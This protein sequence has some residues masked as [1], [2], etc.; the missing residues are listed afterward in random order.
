[1]KSLKDVDPTIYAKA[2]AVLAR[3]P[4]IIVFPLLAA[5]I[6]VGLAFLRGP[7]FDPLGGNDF[8]IFSLIGSLVEGFAFG[9]AL[10]AAES[11]WRGNAVRFNDVWEEGKRKAGAILLATIGFTFVIWLAGMIGSYLGPLS[12]LLQAAAV[13]FLIYTIPAA[14]IGGIPG[15]AALQASIDKVRANY[16][17]AALLVIVS[18]FLRVYV[19]GFLSPYFTE[20]FGTFASYMTAIVEAVVVAYLAVATARQYDEVSFFRRY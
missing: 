2:A 13:F 7:M 19:V 4:L 11:A 6:E 1:M 18:I 5:A 15:G 3:N 17:A 20:P 12:I 16:L 9:L 8:G 14:A 10:I